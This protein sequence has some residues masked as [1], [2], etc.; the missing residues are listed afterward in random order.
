MATRIVL[1]VA[2]LCLLAA[3]RAEVLVLFRPSPLIIA[4]FSLPACLAAAFAHT[5]PYL[6]SNSEALDADESMQG[7]VDLLA[8][9]AAESDSHERWGWRGRRCGGRWGRRCGGGRGAPAPQ[10]PVLDAARV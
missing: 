7:A 9:D 10:H 6:Q 4:I 2:A 3:A 1:V 8:G 5:S